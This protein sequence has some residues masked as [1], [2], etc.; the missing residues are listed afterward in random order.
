MY[1]LVGERTN[2]NR[3]TSTSWRPTGNVL[4]WNYFDK[5]ITFPRDS[6]SDF[7]VEIV[8]VFHFCSDGRGS[9]TRTRP[10]VASSA[11]PSAPT[12]PALLSAIQTTIHQISP[13]VSPAVDPSDA[14][15]TFLLPRSSLGPPRHRTTATVLHRRAL[16]FLRQAFILCTVTAHT[17]R[18]WQFPPAPSGVHS[19]H[20]SVT[21]CLPRS[22]PRCQYGST[23]SD[24]FLHSLAFCL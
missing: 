7:S 22:H 12:G 4:L 20:S 5:V 24:L 9:S 10:A 1:R 3:N 21:P 16:T 13:A 6:C 17:T 8:F 23:L 14:H 2:A 19:S 15:P 11:V 18:T